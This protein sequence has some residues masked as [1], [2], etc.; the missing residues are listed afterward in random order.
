MRVYFNVIR[1]GGAPVL[2]ISSVNS[3][4]L[5]GASLMDLDTATPR[6][7]RRQLSVGALFFLAQGKDLEVVLSFYKKGRQKR[8]R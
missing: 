2:E 3:G 1:S 5:K 6:D 7:G 4:A 8:R